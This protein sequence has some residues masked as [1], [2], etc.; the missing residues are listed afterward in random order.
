M[1]KTIWRIIDE[2]C[3]GFVAMI[4]EIKSERFFW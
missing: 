2:L 3:S 1:L 4:G